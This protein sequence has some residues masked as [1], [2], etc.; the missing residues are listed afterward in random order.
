MALVIIR[1]TI[2]DAIKTWSL[3]GVLVGA[4]VSFY[5][6]NA[7]K[8]KELAAVQKTADVQIARATDNLERQKQDN[9]SAIDAIKMTL[10]VPNLD[11]ARKADL[12][13][14]LEIRSTLARNFEEKMSPTKRTQ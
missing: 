8:N 14:N 12:E 1:N 2:D 10:Q 4:I 11:P 9:Q 5:F 13:K 3:L 7:T 6:T